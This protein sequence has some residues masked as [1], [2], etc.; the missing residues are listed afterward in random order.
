MYVAW[1]KNVYGSFILLLI[2]KNVL[3]PI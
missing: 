3:N 2:E 1:K